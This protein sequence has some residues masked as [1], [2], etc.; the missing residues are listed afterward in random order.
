[1]WFQVGVHLLL[2]GLMRRVLVL[3]GSKPGP[4]VAIARE[5]ALQAL[6]PHVSVPAVWYRHRLAHPVSVLRAPACHLEA[7]AQ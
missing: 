6:A 3:I 5:P 4:P 1:M 2:P 7:A